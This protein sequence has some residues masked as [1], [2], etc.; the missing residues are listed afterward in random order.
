MPTHDNGGTRRVV[1]RLVL[2]LYVYSMETSTT[3]QAA[4][5]TRQR[6]WDVTGRETETCVSVS[7]PWYVFFF[8]LLI[9]VFRLHVQ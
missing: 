9:I 5:D 8:A 7:S 1:S 6:M 2:E 3:A 4:M